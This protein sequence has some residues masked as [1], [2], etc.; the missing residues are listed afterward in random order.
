L[1]GTQAIDLLT[2]SRDFLDLRVE[3][4]IF[5]ADEFVAAFLVG[6][7]ALQYGPHRAHHEQA[8]HGR[9]ARQRPEQ[10]FVPLALGGAMRQ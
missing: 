7:I 6:D 4:A 9:Q 3:L 10:L 8:G 2:Q 5:G 1:P